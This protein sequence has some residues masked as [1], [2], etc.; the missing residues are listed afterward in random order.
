MQNWNPKANEIFLDVIELDNEADRAKLIR[1]A[2][3]GQPELEAEVRALLASYEQSSEFL[4][5]SKVD[6]KDSGELTAETLG[7]SPSETP[8][9][10]SKS[11][12]AGA[13][14]QGTMLDRYRIQQVL[15]SGGMGI[16]YLATDTRLNRRVAI[17]IPRREFHS[18]S[19]RR[20]EREARTMA[21]VKHPNLA[22]LLDVSEWNGIKYLLM[23]YIEGSSLEER[24]SDLSQMDQRTIAQWLCKLSN[25]TACAHEAG[26]IH[27]DIKPSNVILRTNGE[28]VLM[29][30][31]L[32]YSDS[33]DARLT[34]SG[35]I[36]G[37]PAYM[38]P[39]QLQGALHLVGPQSDI[40]ALG[41]IGYEMLTGRPI[42]EGSTSKVLSDLA[43]GKP[44]IAPSELRKDADRNLEAIILKAVARDPKQRFASA[45][46]MS[47]A[48]Q[49]YL[50]G[51][52]KTVRALVQAA[53][54]SKVPSKSFRWITAA[55]FCFVA[56]GA[57][58]VIQTKDGEFVL[59]T[60][61]PAIAARISESGGIT[62]ENRQTKTEYTLRIGKNR[63]PNGDY[64]LIV[65]SPDG[66]ELST[67]QFQ[68]KR[69]DGKAVAT[70]TAR[71]KT[72]TNGSKSNQDAKQDQMATKPDAIADPKQPNLITLDQLSTFPFSERVP[73]YDEVMP[74]IYPT[75]PDDLKRH[76]LISPEYK[77]SEPEC[78][79][80]AIYPAGSMHEYNLTRDEMHMVFRNS[81]SVF[82]ASRSALDQPFGVAEPL[83]TDEYHIFPTV[84]N[85][86]LRMSYCS[87]IGGG[88]G[89]FDLWV[90]TRTSK[91][92]PWSKWQ[93]EYPEI[94]SED[95]DG[96]T[97][98]SSN[99]LEIY[100]CSSRPGS[101]GI[102]DIW[103][104]KRISTDEPFGPPTRLHENMN[105]PAQD[106]APSLCADDRILLFNAFRRGGAGYMDVYMSVRNSRDEQFVYP[107]RF[108]VEINGEYNEGRPIWSADNKTLYFDTNRPGGNRSSDVWCIRRIR[109]E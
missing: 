89:G 43:D 14:D 45:K 77:W 41:S 9:P 69:L 21:S 17:K 76:P 15:G 105:S 67:K 92:E 10:N 75:L 27:R 44:I 90:R 52:V 46:L 86:L 84:S 19:D 35:A 88:K 2:C 11:A 101:A 48:L 94:E 58:F 83:S 85:D 12:E 57:V 39:E 70:V 73:T 59:T 6:T 104:A 71:P 106:Y 47:Q 60:D 51:D 82:V 18:D 33:D 109:R 79:G 28:P 7:I 26:V 24:L 100:F 81:M 53:P 95:N 5:A 36:I 3:Q 22:S 8:F 61:D 4:E 38:A 50:D 20:L 63:L 16:V 103:M 54:Q 37:T 25:A 29:D 72:E 87:A 31:G 102:D 1:Q 91:D 13:F 97:W 66:L 30:F 68:L 34:K 93:L 64:D 42:Y 78:I 49:A 65:S 96:Q 74:S 55:F 80:R 40:Y 98:L 99:G 23:E 62:V 107:I 32:A 108:G 56:L